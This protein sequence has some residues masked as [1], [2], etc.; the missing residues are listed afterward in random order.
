MNNNTPWTTAAGQWIQ[1]LQERSR[2]AK[3]L[4]ER[5]D[6]LREI[7]YAE[8]ELTKS[9][10]ETKLLRRCLF[11]TPNEHPIQEENHV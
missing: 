8:A 9:I 5:E 2:E 10:E 4:G 6:L 1:D 11:L 7:Y 3:T